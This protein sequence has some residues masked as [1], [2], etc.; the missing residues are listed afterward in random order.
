MWVP[1]R[2][3]RATLRGFRV[4]RAGERKTLEENPRDPAPGA[5][6]RGTG[7]K[8]HHYGKTQD[9]GMKAVPTRI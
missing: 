1:K 4:G 3:P 8:S 6:G 5:G 7:L 2:N 9:A